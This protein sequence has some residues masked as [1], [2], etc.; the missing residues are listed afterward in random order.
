MK[1]NTLTNKP[2]YLYWAALLPVIVVSLSSSF[3]VYEFFLRVMPSVITHELRDEFNVG[4]GAMSMMTSCFLYGYAAM[5]IP[6]GLLTDRYGPRKMLSCCVLLCCFA[7][8]AFC[9]THNIILASFARLIIGGAS[10]CA[11]I[12]PLTLASR[13]FQDKHFAMIAGLVQVMGCV[14]AAAGQEP[15]AI[16]AHQVGWRYCMQIAAVVGL[17]LSIFM[18]LIIRDHPPKATTEDPKK[19]S[20]DQ[21]MNQELGRLRSILKRKQTWAI[22]LVSFGCWAP[23]GSFAELWGVSFLKS[24]QGISD[25]VAAKEVVWIWI[26]IALGSPIAGWWSNYIESRRIPLYTFG[27]ISLISCLCITYASVHSV[28]L[29]SFFL[30]M[31][32]IAASAQPISFALV[33]DITPKDRTATAVGFNNM[34]MV[35]GAFLLQPLIGLLLDASWQGAYIDGVHS[36]GIHEFKIAFCLIPVS[37]LMGLCATHF[38][39]K[40]THCKTQHTHG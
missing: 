15:I 19:I 8:L 21:T 17:A 25:A 24:L 5:Q 10:A 33:T 6:A 39:V 3:Y 40:E 7:A 37:I 35:S 32:G 29:M 9:S 36:Y 4:A 16:L 34:A 2:R 18:W 14:G 20:D 12:A 1:S 27:V 11:F 38:W 23:I 30:F 28:A 22:A 13:W 31:L 26:G